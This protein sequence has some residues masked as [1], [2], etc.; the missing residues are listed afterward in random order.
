ME[1]IGLAHTGE[2]PFAC[3]Q[4]NKQFSERKRLNYHEKSHTK[5]AKRYFC[6]QCPASYCSNHGLTQHKRLH[7]GEKPFA[8]D[9]CDK[10]FRKRWDLKEHTLRL[11]SQ[12]KNFVCD[13]C[14]LAFSTRSLLIDH[15]RKHKPR[16]HECTE[17]HKIFANARDLQTHLR[18]HTRE[19]P[20]TCDM[21]NKSFRFR[22]NFNAH[23]KLHMGDNVEYLKC[24]YCDRKF[25]RNADREIHMKS[26]IK[27][28]NTELK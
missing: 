5:I 25:L 12:E 18:T 19:K 20:F 17:C 15:Q 21:C 8:C 23:W 16:I 4:C 24:D 11:H 13:V 6:D 14:Q 26:H 22:Q 7:T 27:E 1:H 10:T 3:T 28:Y 2:K 9:E